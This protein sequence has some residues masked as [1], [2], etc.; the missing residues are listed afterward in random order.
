MAARLRLCLAATFVLALV[1]TST[2]LKAQDGCTIYTIAVAA[3]LD[4]YRE[5]PIASGVDAKGR[6]LQ[7]FATLDGST[8]TIL[9]TTPKGVSCILAAGVD[10]SMPAPSADKAL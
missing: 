1:C 2:P 5:S 6:L 4:K 8:W 7:V 3:L 10:W 9:V